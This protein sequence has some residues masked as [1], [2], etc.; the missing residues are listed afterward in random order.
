MYYNYGNP[1]LS[2]AA[3]AKAESLEKSAEEQQG[4]PLSPLLAIMSIVVVVILL[5]TGR[6]K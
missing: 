4:L 1:D 3:Q 5:Q 6:N 2:Q